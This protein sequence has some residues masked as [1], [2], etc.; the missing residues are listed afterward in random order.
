MQ[1]ATA[2]A[3]LPAEYAAH[4]PDGAA[5]AAAADACVRLFKNM[6]GKSHTLMS[7]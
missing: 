7:G 3:K 2:A 5:D 4:Q 1:L 6:E